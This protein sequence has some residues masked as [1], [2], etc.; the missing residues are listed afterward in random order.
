MTPS[1]GGGERSEVMAGKDTGATEGQ[2]RWY[3]FSTKFDPTFPQNHA[4]LG[5][6]FTNQFWGAKGAGPPVGWSVG[7]SGHVIPQV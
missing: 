6:G 7:V 5:W 4:D 2:I 1:F 3:Q